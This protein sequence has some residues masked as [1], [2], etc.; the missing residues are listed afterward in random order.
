M[1]LEFIRNTITSA[2][3]ARIGQVVDLPEDE[4]RQLVKMNRCVPYESQVIQ[5]HSI[6]LETSDAEPIIRRGRPKKVK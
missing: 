6:G 3:K 2:G 4:G 5:N 1:K